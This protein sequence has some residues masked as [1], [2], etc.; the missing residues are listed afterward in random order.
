MKK[1]QRWSRAIRQNGAT[2][3]DSTTLLYDW[4]RWA[5]PLAYFDVERC[6]LLP[7]DHTGN[8]KGEV[9]AELLLHH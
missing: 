8:A 6:V 5:T 2:W 9:R 3:P 7:F 1:A 4:M